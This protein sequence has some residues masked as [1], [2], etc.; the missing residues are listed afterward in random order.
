M[1]VSWSGLARD[2]PST[3]PWV[4]ALDRCHVLRIAKI[5][6]VDIAS[7]YETR[8]RQQVGDQITV[9]G[10]SRSVLLDKTCVAPLQ[11]PK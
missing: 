3:A 8:A 5:D 7:K 1:E 11:R 2:N 6:A 10:Q 4:I 9:A